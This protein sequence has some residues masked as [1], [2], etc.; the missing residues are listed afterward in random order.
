[1][2]IPM[3]VLTDGQQWSFFLPAEEGAYNEQQVYKLDLL[4]RERLE[5]VSRLNRYLAYGDCKNDKALQA[6]R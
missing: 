6:V 3:A 1:M 4:E 2:G 5:S